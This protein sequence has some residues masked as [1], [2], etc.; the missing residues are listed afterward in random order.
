MLN[1]PECFVDTVENP[2]RQ[3]GQTTAFGVSDRLVAN[4]LDRGLA[5]STCK[6]LGSAV[7]DRISPAGMIIGQRGL[8][9]VQGAGR[10]TVKFEECDGDRC[11]AA[12]KPFT[13]HPESQAPVTAFGAGGLFI[14]GAIENT[15]VG[16]GAKA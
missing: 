4:Q 9:E 10:C 6:I 3:N 14:V 7:I 5:G 1:I 13:V 8:G 12:G 11:L 15:G 2:W 16:P